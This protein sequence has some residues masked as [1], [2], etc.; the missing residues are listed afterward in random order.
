MTACTSPPAGSDNA[1]SATCWKCYSIRGWQSC[2]PIETF[3]KK[4]HVS[5]YL[6]LAQ[7]S[8]RAPTVVEVTDPVSPHLFE[9]WRDV[10][11]FMSPWKNDVF[12]VCSNPKKGG[13]VPKSTFAVKSL[14]Q[15]VCR[16]S[17]GMWSCAS[18][19]N[20]FCCDLLSSGPSGVGVNELRR[21]LIGCNPSCFQSAVPRT[22]ICLSWWLRFW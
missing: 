22:F 21:Q 9:C 10:C 16:A 2:I 1:N 19:S 13:G 6:M 8:L 4:D 17:C 7:R 15:H 11:Y 3:Q 5:D 18:T 14:Q 12:C 20:C